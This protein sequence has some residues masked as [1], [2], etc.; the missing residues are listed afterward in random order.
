MNTELQQLLVSHGVTPTPQ[1]L[2]V[3]EAVAGRRDHPG[4]ETVF[5]SLR[6]AM[7]TL[8]KTT[9]Y[10]ALQLLAEKGLVGTVRG[11][12]EGVRYD[13]DAG[14]HAHFRCKACG[15]LFDVAVAGPHRRPFVDLPDGFEP[16]E[17]DLTYY[18]RCPACRRG[19]GKEKSFGE[20]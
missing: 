14:F 17:E 6:G 18:G 15:G 7:P 4:V 20:A 11:D 3:F 5:A 8:S 9:V 12:R 10:A 16:D 19:A 2:A 13:G 1:R